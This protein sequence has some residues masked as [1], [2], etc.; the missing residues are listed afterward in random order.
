M[1]KIR[2]AAEECFESVENANKWLNM[3]HPLL[4]GKTPLEFCKTS[5]GE[6]NVLDVI[7]RINYNVYD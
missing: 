4:N 6:K 1:D 3:K 5:E 2:K 7:G